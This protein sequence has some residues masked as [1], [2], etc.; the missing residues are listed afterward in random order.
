M[1]KYVGKSLDS[2]QSAMQML[3]LNQGYGLVEHIDCMALRNCSMELSDKMSFWFSPLVHTE[4]ALANLSR[5]LDIEN[6]LLVEKIISEDSYNNL[7]LS[8]NSFVLGPINKKNL[9]NKPDAYFYDGKR[10]YVY[11]FI[12]DGNIIIHEPDGAP[13]LKIG[14][15]EL[16]DFFK[17]RSSIYKISLDADASI[18]N[19]SKVEI[20]TRWLECRSEMEKHP[21]NA[22]NFNFN[23]VGKITSSNKLQRQYA[24]QNYITQSY[25]I[26]NFLNQNRS[27]KQANDFQELAEEIADIAINGEI[28][29]LKQVIHQMENMKIKAILEDLN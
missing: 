2:F 24:L 22:L 16:L 10:H 7:I 28:H 23:K 14:E 8:K 4:E 26:I 19:P 27:G 20:L 12:E 11:C 29:L 25:K 18:K 17:D 6:H 1:Y 13:Y 15:K 21:L 9:I 5:L 3:F